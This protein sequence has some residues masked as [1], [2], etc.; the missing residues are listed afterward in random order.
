MQMTFNMHLRYNDL[1]VKD[2]WAW[3][4]DTNRITRLSTLACENFGNPVSYHTADSMHD[5]LSVQY[6]K[7]EVQWRKMV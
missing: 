6:G 4:P 7:R 5:V 3:Q 2:I 1:V